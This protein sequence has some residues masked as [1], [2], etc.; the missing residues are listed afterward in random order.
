MFLKIDNNEDV[1]KRRMKRTCTQNKNIYN[2]DSIRLIK[3]FEASRKY[4]MHR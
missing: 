1:P 3:D 4:M 2:V